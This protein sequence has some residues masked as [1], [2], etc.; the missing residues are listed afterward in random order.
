MEEM[1]SVKLVGMRVVEPAIQW[2][3]QMNGIVIAK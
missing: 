3:E 1:S 2:S